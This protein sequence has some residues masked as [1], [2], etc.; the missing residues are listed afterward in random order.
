MQHELLEEG[1]PNLLD[2]LIGAAEQRERKC[3][4]ECPRSFEIDD[5]LHSCGLLDR[6][7]S[8]LLAV[9]NSPS[10]NADWSIIFRF[11]ASIAHQTAGRD[12]LAKLGNRGYPVAE[13]QLAKMLDM[14][15]QKLIGTDHECT[16]LQLS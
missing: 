13:C 12:E 6:K 14:A 7:V 1:L 8:W 11:T 4:T 16:R 9:E 10:A 5:K 3:Q 2:D 15:C